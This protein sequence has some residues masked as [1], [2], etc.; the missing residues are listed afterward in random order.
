MRD[1]PRRP[2]PDDL[3]A[4]IRERE[5][6]PYHANG[7]GDLRLYLGAAP[8]VGKTYAMLEEAHR[9]K[10]QG[11]DVVVG[12]VETHGRIGTEA[13]VAGLDVIPRNTITY[14]GVTVEEMD[15]DAILAR[16]PRVAL[17]DE[18]AHTNAPGSSRAKRYEDVQALLAAGINVISTL[19]IQH[20]ESLRDVVAG[21][22]GVRQR[23]TIPD[24]V[25]DAASEIQ[26]VDVPPDVL[27]ARLRNGEIYP[28]ARA[29]QAL[30][31]FFRTG[32]LTALRELALRRVAAGVDAKLE[33]YM[34]DHAITAPWHTMERVMVC[35]DHRSIGETLIRHAWRLVRGLKAEFIVVTV[36][37]TDDLT[38]EKQTALQHA[39]ELAED[40]GATIVTLNGRDIAA[41]L[42]TFAQEQR[43]TQMVI[44][45]PQKSR[46]EEMLRG[47]T[48]NRILRLCRTVDILVVADDAATER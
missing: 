34:D 48:V 6:V 9:L 3:L 15:T 44:G 30:E 13:L 7:R 23:E 47:S 14:K 10:A 17:V 36:Q 24:S 8:G 22:T 41:T 43:V 39:L 12:F 16:H 25:L 21:I 40:L 35:I 27:Q 4:R 19:N 45:H 37:T 2:N 46:W 42:A 18:L 11:V 31:N 5:H 20:L 29:Q 38:P 1:E 28:I 33:T 26:L 32:N